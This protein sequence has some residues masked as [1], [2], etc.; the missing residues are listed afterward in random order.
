MTQDRATTTVGEKPETTNFISDMTTSPDDI[1]LHRK[2]FKLQEINK[3]HVPQV[4]VA[5]CLE[6]KTGTYVDREGV[7]Y[8]EFSLQRFGAC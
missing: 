7:G 1:I 3:C 2:I 4:K 8:N 5:D 6:K